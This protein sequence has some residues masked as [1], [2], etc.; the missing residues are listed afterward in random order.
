VSK[1]EGWKDDLGTHVG[2]HIEVLQVE[3]M[4]PNVNA[5]YGNVSEKRILVGS[6]DNLQLFS[7]G[8]VTLNNPMTQ[9]ISPVT[10]R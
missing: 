3:G 7:G 4:L 8:V 1:W 10:A 5:D 6:R 2:L 9:S